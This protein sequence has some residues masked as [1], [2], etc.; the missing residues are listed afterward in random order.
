MHAEISALE[1]RVRQLIALCAS[2]RDNNS[3]L[4]R[5][6]LAADRTNKQLASQISEAAERLDRLLARLPEEDQ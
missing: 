6:L 5:Q 1:D 4:K 3:A 2:L